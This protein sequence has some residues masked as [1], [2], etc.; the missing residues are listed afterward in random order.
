MLMRFLSLL[1]VFVAFHSL[2]F[3]A[4]SPAPFIGSRIFISLALKTGGKTDLEA[5]SHQIDPKPA[6]ALELPLSGSS[7]RYH[8]GKSLSGDYHG[9]IPFIHPTGFGR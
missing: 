1:L 8:H 4:V 2:L 5:T 9:E 3:T 6:Q 7:P